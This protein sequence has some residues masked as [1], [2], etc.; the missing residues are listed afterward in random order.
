[1]PFIAVTRLRLRSAGYLPKFFWHAT[2]SSAQARK[3]PGNLG[4]DLFNDAKR[5]FWTKSAWK[6]EA[7]MRAYMLTGAHRKAMPTLMDM[8][9]ETHTAHWEQ[10]SATLPTWK[11]VHRRLQETG[12]ASKLRHPS[13]D[14]EA[15]KFAPPRGQ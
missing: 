11:E 2:R 4:V 9:D 13:P 12:R 1:M 7:S 3:A 6:D 8:C 15:R 10:D 5:A 14:H